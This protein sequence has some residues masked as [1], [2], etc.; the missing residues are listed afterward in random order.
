MVQRKLYNK[1]RPIYLKEYKCKFEQEAEAEVEWGK[2][3]VWF[4]YYTRCERLSQAWMEISKRL[5]NL[6]LIGPIEEKKVTWE[7]P[8]DAT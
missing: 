4:Y 3:T 6:I 7:I 2:Y 5:K 1:V 8:S